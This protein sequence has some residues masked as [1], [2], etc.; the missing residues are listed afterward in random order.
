[1]TRRRGTTPP[2]RHPSDRPP[3]GPTANAMTMTGVRCGLA[4]GCLHLTTRLLDS[5]LQCP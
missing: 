2:R 1:M 3:R 4:P 5:A